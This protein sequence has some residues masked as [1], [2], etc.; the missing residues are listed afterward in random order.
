MTR[1]GRFSD[2]HLLVT[3]WYDS[4]VSDGIWAEA[5]SVLQLAAVADLFCA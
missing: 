5:E 4:V 1:E 2:E 3:L